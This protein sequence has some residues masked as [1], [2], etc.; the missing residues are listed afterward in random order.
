MQVIVGSAL[1]AKTYKLVLNTMPDY[2]ASPSKQNNIL[3]VIVSLFLSGADLYNAK[4]LSKPNVFR[5]LT[6]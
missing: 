3:R 4:T 1:F 6:V 5:L 2:K